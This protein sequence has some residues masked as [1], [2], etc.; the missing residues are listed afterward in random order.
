MYQETFLKIFCV[1]V[2]NNHGVFRCRFCI[3]GTVHWAPVSTSWLANNRAM[4]NPP[5]ASASRRLLLYM[6]N[7]KKVQLQKQW[8][9]RAFR[10]HGR[11]QKY[12]VDIANWHIYGHVCMCITMRGLVLCTRR[13]HKTSCKLC[14]VLSPFAGICNL[15]I[16]DFAP[17]LQEFQQ[18]FPVTIISCYK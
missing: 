6:L 1:R 9:G 14:I 2:F 4:A 8:K 18:C 5:C 15:F 17:F 3:A 11:T 16:V 13:P 12:K 7:K 10:N